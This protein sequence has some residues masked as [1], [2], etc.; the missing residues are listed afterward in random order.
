MPRLRLW[1]PV[2]DSQYDAAAITKN[3]YDFRY[4]P[5]TTVP[6]GEPQAAH[7][8]RRHASTIAPGQ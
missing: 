6:V 1:A 4:W 5:G 2:H 3:P 7:A 8:Y